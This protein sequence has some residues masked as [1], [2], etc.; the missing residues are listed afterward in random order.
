MIS[1]TEET[2]FHGKNEKVTVVTVV[3]NVTDRTEETRL[4]RKNEK[5]TVVTVV[6]NVTD[7]T[8]ETQIQDKN[9]KVTVVTVV[10][11]LAGELVCQDQGGK[12]FMLKISTNWRFASDIIDSID[13]LTNCPLSLSWRRSMLSMEALTKHGQMLT[14]QA[15]CH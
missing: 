2:Q 1:M 9:E 3:L 14:T 11:D 6:P 4:Q 13:T 8:E 15:R 5:V 7:R 12:T 10:P